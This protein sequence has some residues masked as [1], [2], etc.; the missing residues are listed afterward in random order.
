M[1]RA[2]HRAPKRSRRPSR[3]PASNR[4]RINSCCS[5]TPARRCSSNDKGDIFYISGRTGKY[6]E[7][8]AGKANWNIFVMARESLRYEL[9]SAFQ[10][11]LRQKE[12]RSPCTES[13][14]EADGWRAMRGYHSPATR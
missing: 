4:W 13:N 11:A 5:I 10:K 2:G 3:R 1:H 9:S 7:P 14:S 8:A 6:L 12:K